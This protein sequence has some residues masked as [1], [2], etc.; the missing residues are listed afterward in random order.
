MRSWEAAAA[1]DAGTWP[2]TAA[3]SAAGEVA[4]REHMRPGFSPATAR[5]PGERRIELA[6]GSGAFFRAVRGS[7]RTHTHAGS[8]PWR[9][10]H[11]ATGGRLA[12][13][14]GSSKE[15]RRRP[16]AVLDGPGRAQHRSLGG[17][18]H[19]G[20]DAGAGTG[21][22]CALLGKGNRTLGWAAA[23]DSSA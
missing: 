12:G 11:A 14:V 6:G 8:R 13:L 16:P 22:G 1:V 9:L 21:G 7:A 23:C 10:P 4:C 5:R 2:A 3:A 20:R 15:A 18:S 19:A 17:R